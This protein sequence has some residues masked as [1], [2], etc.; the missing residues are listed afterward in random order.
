MSVKGVSPFACF[1]TICVRFLYDP[2]LY[3]DCF[4]PVTDRRGAK[5]AVEV[6]PV[7]SFFFRGSGTILGPTVCWG[8]VGWGCCARNDPPVIYVCGMCRGMGGGLRRP[9]GKGRSRG[10]GEEVGSEITARGALRTTLCAPSGR[11]AAKF[12]RLM[13]SSV[14]ELLRG[15]GPTYYESNGFHWE[16]RTTVSMSQ[17]RLSYCGGGQGV[18][19][20]GV[21]REAFWSRGEWRL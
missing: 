12:G 21:W 3:R 14:V 9:G 15:R 16:A 10:E 5:C 17:R 19:R 11:Y 18:C 8:G 13:G 2:L 4:A 1:F 6:A 20:L 7:K